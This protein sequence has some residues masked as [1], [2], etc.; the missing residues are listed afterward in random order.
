MPWEKLDPTLIPTPTLFYPGH[1]HLIHQ[2]D[3]E[4][5]RDD[6]LVIFKIFDKLDTHRGVVDGISTK[7][8]DLDE[9]ES[10]V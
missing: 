10:K 4:E 8:W 7:L 5:S 3:E 9:S 6:L 1:P 2:H